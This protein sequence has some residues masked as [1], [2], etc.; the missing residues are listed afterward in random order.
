MGIRFP[1]ISLAKIIAAAVM[2]GVIAWSLPGTGWFLIAKLTA[3]CLVY[4]ALL[5]ALNEWRPTKHQLLSLR[6]AF[7]R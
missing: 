5:F 2:T 6:Q 7:A 1:W 3:A 4:A